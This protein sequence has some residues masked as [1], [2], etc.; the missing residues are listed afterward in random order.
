MPATPAPASTSCGTP[1]DG[2]RLTAYSL[3]VSRSARAGDRR[4]AAH[5]ARR[6]VQALGLAVPLGRVRAVVGPRPVAVPGDR[7]AVVAVAVARQAVG[8]GDA[9][10]RAETERVGVG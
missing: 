1:P 2:I 3:S 5:E 4:G 8:A 10:E 6:E 7:P 9:A